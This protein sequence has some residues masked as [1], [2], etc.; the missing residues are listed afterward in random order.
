[1]IIAARDLEL[2]LGGKEFSHLLECLGRNDEVAGRRLRFPNSGHLHLREP[3]AVGCDHSHA[4]RT[5]LPKDAVENRPAFFN[6]DCERGMRYQLLQVSRPNSPA[7]RE[8]DRGKGRELV[9]WQAEQLEL[10]SAAFERDSLL[11]YRCDLDRGWRKLACY[12]GELFSGNRNR[13]L[14]FDVSGYFSADGYVEIRTR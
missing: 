9:L 2:F 13:S 1:M 6:R 12:L 14:G 3:V 10:G 5:K 7:V 4:V 11:V 8:F